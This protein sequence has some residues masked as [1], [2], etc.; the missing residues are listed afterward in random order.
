MRRL[1]G[2][3]PTTLYTL[4]L[5]T[6]ILLS[7][8]EKKKITPRDTTKAPPHSRVHEHYL[9]CTRTLTQLTYEMP[10]RAICYLVSAGEEQPM[11]QMH[12]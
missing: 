8:C 1:N 3:E 11:E 9:A 7:G 6:L 4:N 10:H 5:I 2:I 12:G